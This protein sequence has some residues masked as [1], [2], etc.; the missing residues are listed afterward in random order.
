MG[1]CL[2]CAPSTVYHCGP[3][4]CS[5]DLSA[6]R[7]DDGIEAYVRILRS[8]GIDTFESCEGGDTHSFAEPTVRFHGNAVEGFR[9]FAVAADHG[10]PVREVQR[11]WDVIDGTLDGPHWQM[12]FRCKSNEAKR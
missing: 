9:A 5:S 12:V 1:A 4:V 8:K 3:G 2:N 11:V 6:L 7:L 10:L